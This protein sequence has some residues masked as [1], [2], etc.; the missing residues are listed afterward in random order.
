MKTFAIAWAGALALYAVL[1][2]NNDPGAM[3]LVIVLAA[4]I[5]GGLVLA[6]LRGVRFIRALVPLVVLPASAAAALWPLGWDLALAEDARAV[7]SEALLWPQLLV[8]LFAARLIAETSALSAADAWAP[9]APPQSAA[10]HRTSLW[11]SMLL[12]GFI[13]LA[14]YGGL[15]R[16]TDPGDP[17]IFDAFWG[18]TPVNAIIVFVFA[19]ALAEL[20]ELWLG[21]LR[22]RLLLSSLA[23]DEEDDDNRRAVPLTPERLRDRI[24]SLPSESRHG[25]AARRLIGD[26]AWAETEAAAA[27]TSEAVAPAPTPEAAAPLVEAGVEQASRRFLRNLIASLPLIGF[28]GT[29]LGIMAALAALPDVLGAIGVDGGVAAALSGTLGG[30]ATAFQ[31]TLLGLI[32]S[33][34]A[35]LLLAALERAEAVTV[36]MGELLV[37]RA[38]GS[39]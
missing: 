1:T 3:I 16:L 12:A 39:S 30:L 15:V 34:T 33:L 13:T 37:A 38:T 11:S 32:G 8:L 20:G 18:E 17:A 6:D 23:E 25:S 2:L 14:L 21:V 5:G 19:M 29:V 4:M 28:A 10:L 35:S 36:A 27:R 7:L 31:T 22:D 24:A 9:G 26:L